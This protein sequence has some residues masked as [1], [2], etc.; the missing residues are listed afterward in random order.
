V[1]IG[2]LAAFLETLRRRNLNKPLPPAP[3]LASP[4][5]EKLD[6]TEVF[7]GGKTE[8]WLGDTQ[9]AKAKLTLL[10][11]EAVLEPV[12]YLLTE[13]TAFGRDRSYADVV[14]KHKN[15]SR[16]HCRIQ[17]KS[18]QFTVMDEGSA[19]GTYINGQRV[20]IRGQQ[21]KSGD[22]LQ[23][24]PLQYR[25][26][27]LA[28]PPPVAPPVTSSAPEDQTEPWAQQAPM[29]QPSSNSINLP[30]PS[31]SSRMAGQTAEE[32]GTEPAQ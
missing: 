10:T 5:V 31:S 3:Q 6:Q 19:S 16:F 13:N 8:K 22:I 4:A 28:A 23:L 14:L 18:G 17:E 2:A 25:F 7:T 11:G 9:P 20:D 30:G 1:L 26:D 24:G 21:L 12:I 29:A 27:V 15:I 32:S